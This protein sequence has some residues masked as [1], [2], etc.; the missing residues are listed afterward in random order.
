MRSVAAAL[1]VMTLA[2]CDGLGS[3]ALDSTY[4]NLD[5]LKSDGAM[6][7]G[8]VPLW[9]PQ[10]SR[11]ILESHDVD[12]SVSS[13]RLSFAPTEGWSVPSTCAPAAAD[14]LPMPRLK[15]LWWPRGVP[16]AKGEGAKFAYFK[17]AGSSK[18]LVES[19]AVDSKSGDLLYWR[20]HAA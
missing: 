9:V 18:T 1:T 13:L 17:C 14:A 8:W 3:S 19:L 15:P 5:E 2:A 11:I 12:T 4:A 16:S 7:R 20:S 6:E 10:T